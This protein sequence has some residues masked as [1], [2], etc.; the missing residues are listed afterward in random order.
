MKRS[1]STSIILISAFY[2][3][4]LFSCKKKEVPN[5]L[6]P[7]KLGNEFYF[8]YHSKKLSS[9]FFDETNGLEIWVVEN[10]LIQEN[11]II[12][13]IKRKQNSVRTI[14]GYQNDTNKFAIADSSYFQVIEDKK[15]SVITSAFSSSDDI[16]SFQRYQDEM[17]VEIKKEMYNWSWTFLFKSDS[18]LVKRYYYHGPNQTSSSTLKLINLKLN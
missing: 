15:S 4:Y 13:K 10:V 1:L 18:G 9:P 17:Q 16:V 7:L 3:F 14:Y 11:D 5:D 2:A 12:Y 8:K 6:F